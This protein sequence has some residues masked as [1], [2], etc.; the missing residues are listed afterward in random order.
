[1]NKRINGILLQNNR[2]FAIIVTAL[3]LVGASAG[4]LGFAALSNEGLEDI[5]FL[6]YILMTERTSMSFAQVM[7]R[8]FAGGTVFLTIPF[9]MGFCAVSQPLIFLVPVFR[10]LGMG[11]GVASVY[12]SLGLQGIWVA[13]ALILMPAI[14]TVY[15]MTVAVRESFI[16]SVTL[17]SAVFSEKNFI[18]LR[19]AARIYCVKFLV[20][21]AIAAVG[22]CVDALGALLVGGV[23]I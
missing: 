19:D 17:A 20:L 11:L 15:Y 13:A 18:G 8:S 2:N 6:G 22:A 23:N 14:F 7:L 21:E 16:M 12:Y 3:I 9:L 10:G 1:M 4:A 5:S